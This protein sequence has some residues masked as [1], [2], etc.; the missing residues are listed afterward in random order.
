M[1]VSAQEQKEEEMGID[2]PALIMIPSLTPPRPLAGLLTIPK[3]LAIDSLPK[4]HSLEPEELPLLIML[5]PKEPDQGDF[6]NAKVNLHDCVPLLEVDK[7][8][9][10]FICIINA[11]KR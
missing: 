2:L 11:N 8:P 1:Q 4:R 3:P 5:T 6:L 10:L 7:L 9:R